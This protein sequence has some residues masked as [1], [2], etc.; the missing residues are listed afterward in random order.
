[1]WNV[2]FICIKTDEQE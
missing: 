1:M 2:S